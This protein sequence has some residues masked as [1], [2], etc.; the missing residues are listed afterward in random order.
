MT[1]AKNRAGL[2]GRAREALA[3]GRTG[4]AGAEDDGARM[5]AHG[6]GRVQGLA[7]RWSRVVDGRGRV[8]DSIE[9]PFARA[10]GFDGHTGWRVDESGMPGPLDLADLEELIVAA[11]VWSGRWARQGVGGSCSLELDLEGAR[12]EDASSA[13]L[14]LRARIGGV[15]GPTVFRLTLDREHGLP[16]RL[17]R[18]GRDDLALFFE[19]LRPTPF[20]L[21]PHRTVRR[22]AWLE[23]VACVEGVTGEQ[24]PEGE[25]E[26]SCFTR[27]R[28]PPADA[29]FDLE[30]AA[31]P[32]ARRREGRVSGVRRSSG[33]VG[34]T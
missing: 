1:I 34:L 2:L 10:A 18:V 31:A 32:F 23:D 9:G 13:A 5:V 27:A 3:T 15:P 33:V 8:R 14:L 30:A 19:D 20:G 11:H 4:G 12:G 21:V 17:E 6:S 29:S 16:R 22:E 28:L 24:A 7:V 26:G 25:R